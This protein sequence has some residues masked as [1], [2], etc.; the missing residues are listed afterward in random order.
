MG[1]KARWF[2]GVVSLLLVG[3]I[4]LPWM[5]EIGVM[6]AVRAINRAGGHGDATPFIVA[7][8]LVS[9]GAL[10]GVFGAIGCLLNRPWFSRVSLH[11]P[12]VVWIG[13]FVWVAIDTG[14]INIFRLFG[15]IE[16]G[17]SVGLILTLVLIPLSV[18]FAFLWKKA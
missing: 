8:I 4:F 10:G 13:A 6:V 3:A 2:T 15:Q 5:K 18:V 7:L 12:L 14:G 9:V 16:L 11:I 1:T 17:S